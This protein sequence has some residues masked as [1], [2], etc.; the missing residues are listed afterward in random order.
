MEWRTNVYI[1][2][3]VRQATEMPHGIS[4]SWQSKL[5]SSYA[6]MQQDLLELCQRLS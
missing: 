3:L 6:Q 4:R 2:F 1:T 5:K